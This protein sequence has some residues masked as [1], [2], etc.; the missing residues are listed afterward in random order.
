MGKN[1]ACAIFF[2]F[3]PSIHLVYHPI[4]RNKKRT[5]MGVFFSFLNKSPIHQVE[6]S[7]DGNYNDGD[8]LNPYQLAL[9]NTKLNKVRAE[10]ISRSKEK[11]TRRA[12]FVLCSTE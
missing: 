9:D 1:H 3:H 4:K 2:F 8:H 5:H 10:K 7:R 11:K 6:L 12:A